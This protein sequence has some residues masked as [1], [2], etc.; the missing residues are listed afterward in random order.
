MI[1][2]DIE[3]LEAEQR[4]RGAMSTSRPW[5]LI[6]TVKIAGSDQLGEILTDIEQRLSPRGTA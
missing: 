1:T 5:T 4:G 6:I 3:N 2:Y